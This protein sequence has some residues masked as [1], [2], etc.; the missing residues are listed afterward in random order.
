MGDIPP[1]SLFGYQSDSLMRS[2][3]CDPLPSFCNCDSARSMAKHNSHGRHS[4]HWNWRF[5]A[6]I[7]GDGYYYCYFTQEARDSGGGETSIFNTLYTLFHRILTVLRDI[8]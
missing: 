4:E 3:H 2:G 8:D 7:C 6:V 1:P 5:P